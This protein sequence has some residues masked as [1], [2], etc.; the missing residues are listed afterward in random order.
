[1]HAL[2]RPLAVALT[3]VATTASAGVTK[4]LDFAQADFDIAGVSLGMVADD[5]F[6]ALEARGYKPREYKMERGPSF[7][8]LLEIAE[9]NLDEDTAKSDWESAFFIK[10]KETIFLDFTPLPTGNGVSVIDYRNNSDVMNYDTFLM[11]AIQKFGEPSAQKENLAFWSDLPLN[12]DGEPDVQNEG[13]S[14]E[15]NGYGKVKLLLTG[16]KIGLFDAKE[17]AK[18]W[19]PV[20]KTTF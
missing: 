7:G 3:I 11:L 19:A 16:G 15:L 17:E 20:P 12:A 6:A 10:G 2:I 9:G 14:L 13:I 18:D 4:V 1:M 8:D 5:A